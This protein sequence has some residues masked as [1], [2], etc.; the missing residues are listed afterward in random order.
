MAKSKPNTTA[1]I[2][3]VVEANK[4][5]HAR[6]SWNDVGQWRFDYLS[7]DQ[8]TKDEAF[9]RA[10]ECLITVADLCAVVSR[11]DARA[12][13]EDGHIFALSNLASVAQSLTMNACGLL[14]LAAQKNA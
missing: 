1:T 6:P 3:T 13:I 10:N 11:V 8:M 14:E 5:G 2:K 12:L 4:E 7:N 9:T